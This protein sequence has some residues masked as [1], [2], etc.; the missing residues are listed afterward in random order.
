MF[1]RKLA[2]PAVNPQDARK[3]VS[4]VS[5]RDAKLHHLYAHISEKGGHMVHLDMQAELTSRM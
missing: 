4:T 2:A 5:S 3:L 1:K